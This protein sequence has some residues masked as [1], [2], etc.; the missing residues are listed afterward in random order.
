MSKRKYI[1]HV[2]SKL[3]TEQ[4]ADMLHTYV[5]NNLE[6]GHNIFMD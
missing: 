1:F 6:N 2:F 5:D 3:R 4:L